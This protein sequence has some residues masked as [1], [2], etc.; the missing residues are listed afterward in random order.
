MSR[1]RK[2]LA[3]FPHGYYSMDIGSA[4]AGHDGP[5]SGPTPR[6]SQCMPRSRTTRRRIGEGKERINQPLQTE[7]KLPRSRKARH[8]TT[9]SAF[10]LAQ[11][12]TPSLP[13]KFD[14]FP[15]LDPIMLYNY[16]SS[17]QAAMSCLAEPF[18]GMCVEDEKRRNKV[19]QC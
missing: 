11:P 13:I 18:V 2:H 3:N 10:T 12:S 17:R 8:A 19:L 6:N 16:I 1:Q 4:S 9:M 7:N 5:K 15:L 14:F